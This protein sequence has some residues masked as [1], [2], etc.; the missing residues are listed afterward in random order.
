[1]LRSHRAVGRDHGD[2]GF[3]AVDLHGGAISGGAG[4][5]RRSARSV[6]EHASLH[7]YGQ[8]QESAGGGSQQAPDAAGERVH[9]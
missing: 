3:A 7:D 8:E 9:Q 4:D 2:L 1:M 5:H 6:A